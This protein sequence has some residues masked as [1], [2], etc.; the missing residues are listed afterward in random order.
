MQ[1]E[2]LQSRSIGDFLKAVYTLQIGSGPSAD[3]GDEEPRVS[4]NALAEYL[5]ISAPSVT[6]MA[7]RM[8]ELEL[9][10]YRKYHGVRL[11]PDGEAIALHL[12]RRHRL[13][14]L[15]LVQELGYALHEVHDEAEVLE[16]SV[17]DRFITTIYEKLGRP[18]HDPHGDPIPTADGK[19][20]RRN[21]TRLTEIP[22]DT[23]AI[24]RRYN[25]QNNDLIEH[26]LERGFVL[27]AEVTVTARDPFDGPVTSQVNEETRVLGHNVATCIMVELE[28]KKTARK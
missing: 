22:L 14:E 15:Y 12:I 25:T 21:L 6:D 19:V 7:R 28:R 11:S 10:D 23:V 20:V 16:H 27:G 4:T 9:V 18:T 24:V 26:I 5:N 8:E 3:D 1:N 13:I 2:Y 17:S